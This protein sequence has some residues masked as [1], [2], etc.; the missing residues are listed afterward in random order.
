MAEEK[1]EPLCRLGRCVT[2]GS[3]Y[4]GGDETVI[5]KLKDGIC[6][7]CGGATDK[8]YFSQ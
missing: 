6:P 1:K 3:N 4:Q 2:K 8:K 5:Q 7:I